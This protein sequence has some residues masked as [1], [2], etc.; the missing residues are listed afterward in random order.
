MK[1]RMTTLF[2]KAE[3]EMTIK[4]MTMVMTKAHTVV[5]IFKYV[6]TRGGESQSIM[7]P[8]MVLGKNLSA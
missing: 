5:P 8:R 3:Y 4:V 7:S 6:V 1:T 2:I